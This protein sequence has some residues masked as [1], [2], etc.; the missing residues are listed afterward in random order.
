MYILNWSEYNLN[1]IELEY[2]SMLLFEV[3]SMFKN[4]VKFNVIH[5]NMNFLIEEFKIENHFIY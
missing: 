5:N 1:N 2:L 3:N 4:N